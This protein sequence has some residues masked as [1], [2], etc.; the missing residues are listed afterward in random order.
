MDVSP[1]QVIPIHPPAKRAMV[2]ASPL[3]LS[4]CVSPLSNN[5]PLHQSVS[6]NESRSAF[7][8][9]S[10]SMPIFDSSANSR[11]LSCSSPGGFQSSSTSFSYPTIVMNN[12]AVSMPPS[13]SKMFHMTL[14]SSNSAHLQ[15]PHL[16][17]SSS[18]R[19]RHDHT[20][21]VVLALSSLTPPH[22][23]KHSSH[24][25]SLHSYQNNHS[26]SA[27]LPYKDSS[28]HSVVVPSNSNHL[29][30]STVNSSNEEQ[31]ISSVPS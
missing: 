27:F 6:S 16:S 19:S 8:P 1:T 24:P 11:G 26:A 22:S 20:S 13:S 12:T 25:P 14:E 10:S 29:C 31:F 5:S 4:P 21:H 7:S 2:F 17:I 18:P 15:S 28:S 3:T 30:D 23:H 9:A